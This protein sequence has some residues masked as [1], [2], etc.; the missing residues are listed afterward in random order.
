M[1]FA[2]HLSNRRPERRRIARTGCRGIV[3]VGCE[4][5]LTPQFH[6]PLPTPLDHS[7]EVTEG[8]G[9]AGS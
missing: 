7:G 2:S 5:H 9:L 4:L 8:W 1:P 3:T 6:P